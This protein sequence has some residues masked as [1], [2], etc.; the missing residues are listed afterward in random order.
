MLCPSTVINLDSSYPNFEW[1]CLAEFLG[2][3]D[4]LKLDMLCMRILEHLL[5]ESTKALG[6]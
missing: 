3:N 1:P 2:V 6:D 5:C 4:L